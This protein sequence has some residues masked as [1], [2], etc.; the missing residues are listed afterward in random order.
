[1]WH[2][3]Q[4]LAAPQAKTRHFERLN[5]GSAI[6]KYTSILNLFFLLLNIIKH[7]HSVSDPD[8]IDLWVGGLAEESAGKK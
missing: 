4:Q 7:N 2:E 6:P 3:F 8:D 1:M 5:Y